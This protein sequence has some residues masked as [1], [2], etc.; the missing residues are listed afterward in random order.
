MK[1]KSP[2]RLKENMTLTSNKRQYWFT[3][4]ARNGRILMTSEMY[5][6][7]RSRAYGV[8]A[9]RKAMEYYK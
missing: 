2:I 4:H 8:Q 7:K 3:L 5:N 9:V 6:T 1:F